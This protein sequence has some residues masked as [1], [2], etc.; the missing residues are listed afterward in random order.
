M[1]KNSLW[2]ILVTLPLALSFSL[3]G[4]SRIQGT[5][6]ADAKDARYVA[7]L[8]ISHGSRTIEPEQLYRKV[9]KLIGD[10]FYE[11]DFNGQDWNR[12]RDRYDGKL[13]TSDDAHKAIETMLA[14]LGDRYT[15]FLDK[16]AFD[17]EKGQIEAKLFGVGIQIGMDKNQRVVV[18]AP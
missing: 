5:A 18:I 15:R 12:W 10:D 7:Q 17:D 1:P 14:S 11:Q 2:K 16:D 9:W 13:K 6:T 4:T 8:P 3:G